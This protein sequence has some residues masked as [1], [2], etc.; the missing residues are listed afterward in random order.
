MAKVP[1]DVEKRTHLQL[2]A[3]R[4]TNASLESTRRSAA[5]CEESLGAGAKTQVALHRQGD[6]LD[7][8]GHS[9]MQIDVGLREASGNLDEMRRCCCLCTLPCWKASQFEEACAS[10]SGG[11]G[12]V[13]ERQP[14]RL[15]P[16]QVTSG[17]IPRLTDDA[18]ED[19][20][21][22][23]LQQ[24]SQIIGNMRNMALD[25]GEEVK[26]QEAQVTK[27]TCIAES[28][29][30]HLK[31][32][33]A[34]SLS[35]LE[36]RTHLQLEADRVTNASLEST[37][38]SA[39]MCEESLGAGAKTQV[40]LHRQG[41]QL[42][43][44]GHSMMQIDM[45]VREASGNLDEMRR[46]CCLCTLPCWKASQFEEAGVWKSGGNGNVVGRQPKRLPPPQVTSG[47]IPRLTDDAREDEMEANV[48]R[49]SQIIGNMRAMALD[50]GYEVETQEVQMTKIAGIAESNE[51]QLKHVNQLA[52]KIMKL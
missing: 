3:N 2:E 15:P 18:R 24:I 44:V 17:Y 52:S 20:M 32:E 36:T 27:I 7:E 14:Q 40:A 31:H 23:N 28:N 19:E 1:A 41:D 33:M 37:R 30:T 46:C 34:K 16:P 45:G 26:A 8:V 13:V 29:E 9:M 21:E 47:Y 25:I 43:E 35:A 5:M 6:Q 10:K 51:I 42:N 12:K 49:I 4:V 22:A 50:I 39:A 48:Q 11:D 38:R